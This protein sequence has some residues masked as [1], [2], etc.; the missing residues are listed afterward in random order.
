[1]YFL[2]KSN[3]PFSDHPEICQLQRL[4]CIDLGVTLHSRYSTTAIVETIYHV[5]RGILCCFITD[6]QTKIY[7]LLDGSTTVSRKSAMVVYIRVSSLVCTGWKDSGAITFQ[8]ELAELDALEAQTIT[9]ALLGLL[10]MHGFNA[11]YLKANLIGA[12]SYGVSTILSSRSGVLT[13][14]KQQFP[15]VQLWHCMCHRIELAIGD[16]VKNQS[17]INNMQIFIDKLYTL[18][19]TS[20]RMQRELKSCSE[21][22]C[23]VIRIG[24]VWGTRWYASSRRALHAIWQNY[25]ALAQH[26]ADNL[27][28]PTFS[29]LHK[30]L[31]SSTFL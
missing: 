28:K 25:P 26:F 13:R 8:L 2:A 10:A 30:I 27:N 11:K 24:R 4:N 5:M 29:G 20:P 23:D 18:Y 19:P 12:C 22:L 31:T 7:V 6:Q 15:R 14:L 9:S 16:S 21:D 1:M 3:R 17:E